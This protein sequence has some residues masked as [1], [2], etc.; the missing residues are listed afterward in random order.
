MQ[1]SLHGI[2]RL[3][4]FRLVGLC[5]APRGNS[6]GLYSLVRVFKH[7]L[8]ALQRMMRLHGRLWKAAMAH[9]VD[10]RAAR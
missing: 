8:L 4:L 10:P 7:A 1:T 5:E 6:S 2:H 9:E 3:L